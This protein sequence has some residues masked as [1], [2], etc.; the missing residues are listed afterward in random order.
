MLKR[1]ALLTEAIAEV[2]HSR[3]IC[4]FEAD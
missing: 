4:G 3:D 2:E 1:E